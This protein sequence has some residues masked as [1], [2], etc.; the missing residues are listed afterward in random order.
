MF[1]IFKD[2]ILVIEGKDGCGKNTVADILHEKLHNSYI[3][4]FPDRT[5]YSGDVINLI[6][7]KKMAFPDG[8]SFQA[9]Q[10]AN[11]IETLLKVDKETIRI[12][13]YFIMCRYTPS[14]LVYGTI[15]KVDL[16][17]SANISNVLP[18]AYMTFILD[19]KNYRTDNVEYYETD[20]KQKRVAELYL[21]YAQK[22]K[23]IVLD[24]HAKPEELADTILRKLIA[25]EIKLGNEDMVTPAMI[26]RWCKMED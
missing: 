4:Y 24:N 22:F 6:L 15:D 5:N 20:E 12:P 3:C 16:D 11:K 13:R 26:D 23:W 7:Q 18:K 25:K 14:T 2:K 19:G 17:F 21:E 10:L 9:L 8:C 1:E